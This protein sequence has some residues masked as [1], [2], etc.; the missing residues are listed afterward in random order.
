MA[1]VADDIF[2][3]DDHAEQSAQWET[4]PDLFIDRNRLGAHLIAIYFDEGIQSGGSIDL[5]EIM[6]HHTDTG[7]YPGF[8]VSLVRNYGT[9]NVQSVTWNR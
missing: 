1:L 4:S 6:I 7:H 2:E 8:Q 5:G 9:V 3:P